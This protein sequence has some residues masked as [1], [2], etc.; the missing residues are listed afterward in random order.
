MPCGHVQTHAKVCQNHH[1]TP[2]IRPLPQ[3]KKV[4][5]QFKTWK[6]KMEKMKNK[7]QNMMHVCIA[8]AGGKT[9]Q[10]L[11]HIELVSGHSAEPLICWHCHDHLTANSCWH[12]FSLGPHICRWDLAASANERSPA[13]VRQRTVS[14]SPDIHTHM[15]LGKD[16]LGLIAVMHRL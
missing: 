9:H 10:A 7:I 5:R 14:H 3:R 2:S 4:S 13:H 8:N 16:C 15:N 11:D 6:N 12:L 1:V